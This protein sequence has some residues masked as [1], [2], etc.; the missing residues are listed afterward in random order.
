MRMINLLTYNL[1]AMLY[2]TQGAIFGV[3][4]LLLPHLA[5]AE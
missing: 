1:T 5:A 4:L 2:T 3:H